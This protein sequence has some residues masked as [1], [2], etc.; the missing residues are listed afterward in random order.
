M[1]RIILSLLL[2]CALPAMAQKPLTVDRQ[3]SV[4]TTADKEK[5]VY[6]EQINAMEQIDMALNR[7]REENKYVLCQVGG[8]WCPWCLRFALFA[9]TNAVV[10]QTIKEN[11]VYIHV[12]HSKANPNDEAMMRLENPG[13]FGYPVFV[14]LDQDGHR[15]HTQNSSYLEEGKG[16]S[17]KKVNEFLLQ[18]T[19]KAI[20]TYAGK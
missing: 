3:G 18:W 1:K 9:D 10:N 12:N 13:R 8:N 6:D 20:Q 14:I 19:A 15:I 5:R 16:Y 7:A 2:L 17:V 11:Y 4:Q